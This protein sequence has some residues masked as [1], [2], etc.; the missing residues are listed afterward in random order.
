[1]KS[2]QLT[3]TIPEELRQKLTE[4]KER[5]YNFNISAV[6]AQA[7]ARK[8]GECIDIEE[9]KSKRIGELRAERSAQFDSVENR[10][11]HLGIRDAGKSD[12]KLIYFQELDRLWERMDKPNGF[13]TYEELYEEL[14]EN[15][16]D[17]IEDVFYDES[18]N[19]FP[20]ERE[21]FYCWYLTGVYRAW[22]KIRDEV[23]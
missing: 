10:L 11:I 23:M 4:F 22:C 5:G 6:C 2:T 18:R 9:A 7:L 17:Y 16:R 20:F 13:G 1:M 15:F 8:V 21:I 3:V 19:N 14:P 12:F